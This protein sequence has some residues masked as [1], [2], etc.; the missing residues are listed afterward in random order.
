VPN[1]FTVIENPLHAFGA[2]VRD[3]EAAGLA[4]LKAHEALPAELQ[5]EVEPLLLKAF[6]HVKGR[7]RDEN[8]DNHPPDNLVL[9]DQGHLIAWDQYIAGRRVSHVIS[10]HHDAGKAAPPAEAHAQPPVTREHLMRS[11]P[12]LIAFAIKTEDGQTTGYIKPARPM[13]YEELRVLGV[14]GDDDP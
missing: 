7:Q 1:P 10:H 6:G 5:A 14:L 8:N 3:L 13:T 9:D 2:A 4:L 11:L 12:W